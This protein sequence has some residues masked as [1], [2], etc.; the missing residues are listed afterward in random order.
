[1]AVSS[2][3]LMARLLATGASLMATME[4]FIVATLEL[5]V[6]SFTLK[7]KESEPLVL[8]LGV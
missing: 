7:V 2:F 3:V 6:P 1:L 8:R 4:I 5:V